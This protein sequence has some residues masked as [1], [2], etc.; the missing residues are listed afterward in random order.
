MANNYATLGDWKLRWVVGLSL[1]ESLLNIRRMCTTCNLLEDE[2][3]FVIVSQ[4]AVFYLRYFNVSDSSGC[5]T[6]LRAMS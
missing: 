3:N 6:S 5:G 1:K 2:Y 4:S